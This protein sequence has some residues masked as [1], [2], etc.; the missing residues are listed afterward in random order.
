MII[1]DHLSAEALKA[2]RHIFFNPDTTRLE[3]M[4]SIQAS[5]LTVS[6]LLKKL[7]GS[8][9]IYKSGKIQG[10]SGR[11]S[12]TYR[13]VKNAGTSL[14]VQLDFNTIRFVLIDASSDL[15][16]EWVS[17]CFLDVR[18]GWQQDGYI[19][20]L[21]SSIRGGLDAIRASGY[22]E[23]GAIGISLPGMVDSSNGIWISGLQL[24]GIRN[25]PLQYELQQRLQL[26]VFIED[27]SRSL[28]TFEK[29][30]GAARGFNNVTLL[31]LGIGMGASIVINDQIVRGFHGTA[32]EIGHIPH[33]NSSYR[34]SCGNIGCFETIV[35]P[36]GIIRIF[37]DRLGEGVSSVL[38]KHRNQNG[39]GYDLSLEAIL[40]AAKNGDHLTIRTLAEIGTYIGD[41]CDILIKL[42]NPEILIIT[43]FSSIFSD[44]L[45]K[46]VESTI[47][48]KIAPE[49]S[50]DFKV[51]FSNYQPD[52][53]AWGAAMV[54]INEL[55]K[56]ELSNRK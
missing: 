25:I 41:A 37:S 43:G 56:R 22:I 51:V 17:D 5:H 7:E 27:N 9:L 35:G 46:S 31:Y 1:L 26:P 40:E 44:Y 38:Q 15:L 20:F 34:C 8:N 14:G 13:I 24:Q 2:L 12:A 23:P 29:I 19:D 16:M 6:T 39:P 18:A 49:I 28:I 52:F 53:E 3:L 33:G 21:E 48:I 36:A 50:G 10:E 42:F 45:E 32:G 54:A 47:S 30:R 11:P 4:E 55:L